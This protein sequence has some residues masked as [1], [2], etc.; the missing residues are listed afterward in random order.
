MD[1]SSI[2]R[3]QWCLLLVVAGLVGLS[4]LGTLDTIS[5]DYVGA[6]LL[7]AGIIYG[8]ARGIN[9]LVSALQ[10]TELD[11]WL[12]TFSVGELLDPVNDMIE[13]FSGVMT[14]AITS[15]VI[16][17]LLLV[18]VSDATFSAVLTL[19][20]VAVITAL[21]VNK[22]NSYKIFLKVF[23]VVALL[24]FSL[25]L[26]VIANLWVDQAFLPG[27]D[28]AEFRVMQDFEADLHGVDRMIR[29]AGNRSEIGGQ[30][31]R[32]QDKFSRFVDSSLHLMGA[33]LLKSVIVPVL[34][35]WGVVA[36]G[37]GLFR[38]VP[39]L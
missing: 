24:R 4:W 7:D 21:L 14:I 37:R 34:F 30:F 8:T 17:Q 2:S 26:V 33:L 29:G 25:S 12:V 11:L 5:G 6:S 23:L 35:L 19:L 3:S 16:Q 32:L 28:A 15:L 9:A 22:T 13:R 18:I 38:L 1:V 31:N 10:G 20:A 39:E 36:A 27:S